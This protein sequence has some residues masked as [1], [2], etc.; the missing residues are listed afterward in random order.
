MC[1][2]RKD[3]ASISE[4]IFHAAPPLVP[5]ELWRSPSVYAK[6]FS[7]PRQIWVVFISHCSMNG[8]F[9]VP[10][11]ANCRAAAAAAAFGSRPTRQRTVTALMEMK[12]AQNNIYWRKI[13]CIQMFYGRWLVWACGL[14]NQTVLALPLQLHQTRIRREHRAAVHRSIMWV[15]H[16]SYNSS[17]T[18]H[19]EDVFLL[20]HV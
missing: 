13:S 16:R 20:T 6:I 7:F 18:R 10:L 2:S 12:A 19:V 9:T 5:A 14:C 11:L 17:Q 8:S 3:F 15:F 1:P 4:T